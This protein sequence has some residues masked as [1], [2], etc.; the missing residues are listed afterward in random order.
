MVPSFQAFF[1]VSAFFPLTVF[2]SICWHASIYRF[3]HNDFIINRMSAILLP[4]S[5]LFLALVPSECLVTWC[6]EV[7]R[8]NVEGCVTPAEVL[9]L[10]TLGRIDGK[11]CII[12]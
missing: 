8:T 9:E 11:Y 5:C 7:A 10:V 4:L 3:Y 2:V 6:T 12:R 1:C